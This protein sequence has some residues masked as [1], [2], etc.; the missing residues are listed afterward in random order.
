MKGELGNKLK[1]IAENYT[2]GNNKLSLAIFVLVIYFV[3]MIW[4]IGIFSATSSKR[5]RTNTRYC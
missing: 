4:D 3:V 1:I 2:K 5:R